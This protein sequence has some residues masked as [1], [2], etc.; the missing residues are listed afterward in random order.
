MTYILRTS[1]THFAPWASSTHNLR[2][3]RRRPPP[4]RFQFFPPGGDDGDSE[5]TAGVTTEPSQLGTTARGKT[6]E[7]EINPPTHTRA[8]APSSSAVQ[9]QRALF[10]T[11]LLPLC[12]ASFDYSSSCVSTASALHDRSGVALP[13]VIR[14][15][16]VLRLDEQMSTLGRAL[17]HKPGLVPA[18]PAE[19]SVPG[20]AR[21]DILSV[22]GLPGILPL[23]L[24]LLRTL[25]LFD[26]DAEQDVLLSPSS[27]ERP[28]TSR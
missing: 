4:T 20:R 15:L 16:F 2:E 6:V 13:R 27:V 23:H 22:L 14:L 19:S 26:F 8:L 17:A 5:L 7:R 11:P 21:F 9:D 25:N 3:K 18:Y 12:R 24:P 1:A 28:P 10:T